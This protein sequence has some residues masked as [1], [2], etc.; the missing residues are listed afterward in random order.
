MGGGYFQFQS[1]QLSILPICKANEKEREVL[2]KL[3]EKMAS[4]RKQAG[5]LLIDFKR[6]F[7]PM[8]AYESLKFF[9]DPLPVNDKEILTH[10]A[11]NFS[12]F[13]LQITKNTGLQS[14]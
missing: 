1:P 4:L 7:E 11:A 12:F 13:R 2:A 8:I 14:R 9:C 5:K 3:A 10:M 6:Y